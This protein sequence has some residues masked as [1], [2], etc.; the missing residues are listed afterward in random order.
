MHCSDSY[1]TPKYA[2]SPYAVKY[3]WT[4]PRIPPLVL[5]MK[6]WLWT[7]PYCTWGHRI[8]IG[9]YLK[10]THVHLK[11]RGAA[12]FRSIFNSPVPTHFG[13][14]EVISPLYGKTPKC[15]SFSCLKLWNSENGTP[16]EGNSVR[17]LDSFNVHGTEHKCTFWNDYLVGQLYI[18]TARVKI[19]ELLLWV[20]R[21][22]QKSSRTNHKIFQVQI[23]KNQLSP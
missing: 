3:R 21:K 2:S 14:L 12:K 16:S 8:P 15:I 5:V 22:N 1:W 17:Y 18:I 19:L 11:P 7:Y 6:Y 10:K 20:E 4:K 23:T 9:T 13:I